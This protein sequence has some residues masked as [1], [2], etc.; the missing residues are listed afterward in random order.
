MRIFQSIRYHKDRPGNGCYLRKK[1]KTKTTSPSVSSTFGGVVVVVVVVVVV[2]CMVTGWVDRAVSSCLAAAVAPTPT[3][4]AFVFS[5][6]HHNNVTN[7]RKHSLH[8]HNNHRSTRNKRCFSW[9]TL[10]AHQFYNDDHNNWNNHDPNPATGLMVTLAKEEQDRTYTALTTTTTTT[11]SLPNKKKTTTTTTKTAML[12]RW[13]LHLPFW[14]SRSSTNGALASTAVPTEENT[15]ILHPYQKTITNTHSTQPLPPQKQ[16]TLSSSHPPSVHLQL[17]NPNH[18]NKN[19]E[20]QAPGSNP[21]DDNLRNQPPNNSSPATIS[22]HT[23]RDPTTN[24]TWKAINTSRRKF[25]AYLEYRGVCKKQMGSSYNDWIETV[26]KTAIFWDESDRQEYRTLWKQGQLLTDRTEILSVYPSEKNNNDHRGVNGSSSHH[27]RKKRGG[28]SDLLY[29]YTERIAAILLDEQEDAAVAQSMTATSTATTRSGTDV[30]GWLQDHYGKENT[31]ALRHENFVQM[32]TREQLERLK[33][34]LEWF[35]SV[36]PYF[37][38]RCEHCGASIK[39]DKAAAASTTTNAA[40]NTHDDS[41]TPLAGDANELDLEKEAGN[42]HK[43]FVGYIYPNETEL[44]GKASR[45]EL[46]QCHVCESFTRFPRFNSASHVINFRKGRC[47]EYSMLLFRFLRALQHECRWVVDWA[48]HVWAEVLIENPSFGHRWVHLDPCEAAVDEN[49]LYQGWGKKQTYIL[50][51]YLPPIRTVSGT[52]S[53]S[54]SWTGAWSFQHPMIEDITRAYTRE[55][56]IEVCKRR[57][58]SDDQV[59]EAIAKATL[60]LHEKLFKSAT[61]GFSRL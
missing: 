58:E 21:N 31:D 37:Y 22:I 55:S 44:Q 40:T 43:T 19:P 39:E 30:I 29:L 5:S 9:A 16:Q 2:L 1:K 15:E 52:S 11:Y 18:P 42:D 25:R 49:Y 8:Q 12:G 61:Y 38:D 24:K 53:A 47:G 36:F 17:L 13:W 35:R 4:I 3:T 26:H 28:F 56:W 7:K 32:G 41:I 14:W 20:Q 60:Q 57:E 51:F 45:T 33:H 27:L 46:Y 6:N 48:D 34:F 59:Q 10:A 50:G 54:S 23:Y